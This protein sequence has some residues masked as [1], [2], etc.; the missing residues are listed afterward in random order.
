[1]ATFQCKT[2]LE[3]PFNKSEPKPGQISFKK[4]PFMLP[5]AVLNY[6]LEIKIM[7][8]ACQNVLLP[9]K[10]SSFSL[11]THVEK[12]HA[13]KQICGR[14]ISSSAGSRCSPEVQI[15]L[16]ARLQWG[17]LWVKAS[18]GDG[19][20]DLSDGCWEHPSPA[21]KLL[22]LHSRVDAT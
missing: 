20:W 1:M 10:N 21:Q 2:C 13:R 19:K 8:F 7:D 6:A 4:G 3:K 15:T 18:R 14:P 16:F 9:H 11:F 5:S 17:Y 22:G 12:L